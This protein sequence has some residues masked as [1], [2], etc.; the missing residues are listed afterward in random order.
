LNVYSNAT[1]KENEQS[2]CPRSYWIGLIELSQWYVISSFVVI[3]WPH[4]FYHN[5][6]SCDNYYHN[7]QIVLPTYLTLITYVSYLRHT[8]P[9]YTHTLT[10]YPLTY[11]TYLDPNNLHTLLIYLTIYTFTYP[12]NLSTYN[13][14]TL[15]TYDIPPYLTYLPCFNQSHIEENQ[16]KSCTSFTNKRFCNLITKHWDASMKPRV[17]TRPNHVYEFHIWWSM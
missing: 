16:W 12:N 1:P 9:M 17:Q 11:H 10:I 13:L 5:N 15:P 4:V 6:I 14:L 3:F 2:W 7:L 8:Y